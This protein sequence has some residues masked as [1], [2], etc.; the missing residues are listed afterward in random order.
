MSVKKTQK[1]TLAQFNEVITDSNRKAAE[2]LVKIE[3]L[4]G[5][6]AQ[7][8]KLI[9]MMYSDHQRAFSVYREHKA[10]IHTM[11]AIVES[12]NVAFNSFKKSTL[13]NNAAKSEWDQTT[14]KNAN[15]IQ[16]LILKIEQEKYGHGAI[17]SQMA[18]TEAKAITRDRT[19]TN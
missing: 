11:L 15:D 5:K 17:A 6:I 4:E 12:F 2:Y 19:L 8:D 13:E 16:G 18:Q 1:V 14:D 3:T 10:A 9:G 7:R